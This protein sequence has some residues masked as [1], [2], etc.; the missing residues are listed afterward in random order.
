MKTLLLFLLVGTFLLFSS[1]ADNKKINGV[2]YRPYGLFNENEC[3]NDDIY[4]EVSF[5]AIF[6]GIVFS[7]CFFI[8]TIYTFGYNLYE[9]IGPINE[10][11]NGNKGVVK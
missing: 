10:H 3:K 1:C 5:Q 7:K 8:P 6:S 9:P 11:I 4:Y 2:T